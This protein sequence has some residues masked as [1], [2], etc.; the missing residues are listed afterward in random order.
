MRL[1]AYMLS[2]FYGVDARLCRLQDRSLVIHFSVGGEPFYVKFLNHKR[3]IE[4]S[5]LNRVFLE[6]EGE[7]WIISAS[8]FTK[9]SFEILQRLRVN[10]V[11][12]NWKFYLRSWPRLDKASESK[13]RRDTFLSWHRDHSPQCQ[14]T[15][16]DIHLA[17]IRD[18]DFKAW[19]CEKCQRF[20]ED[21]PELARAPSLAYGES[22][23][24][25]R[26]AHSWL[27][28][29]GR[30]RKWGGD[31][32]MRSKIESLRDR[33]R[34]TSQAPNNDPEIGAVHDVNFRP[35]SDLLIVDSGKDPPLT[36]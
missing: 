21:L 22:F 31:L 28:V 14:A 20:F 4:P 11:L 12:V 26:L 5:H 7:K 34:K 36:L 25:E 18:I 29:R 23:Y 6:L 1:I 10:R 17:E 35:V 32:A 33:E 8:T 15:R 13:A 30:R 19:Y 2:R 16:R 9:A 27:S 3:K 24:A